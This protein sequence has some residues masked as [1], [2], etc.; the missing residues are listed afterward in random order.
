LIGVG[1]VE[2]LQEKLLEIGVEKA[3]DYSSKEGTVEAIK[4]ACSTHGIGLKT[5]T[6]YVLATTEWETAQTFKPVREAF[7][8][9]EE[10]RR[11]N[12]N[13]YPYYGRG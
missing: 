1:S 7:W 2:K 10:W 12:L 6:A 8:L 13:Y 4:W 11:Q 3:H 9:S 5:Q